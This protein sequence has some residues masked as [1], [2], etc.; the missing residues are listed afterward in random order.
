MIIRSLSL[1]NFGCLADREIEFRP[2][3]NVIRGPNEAGKST[4]QSALL[5]VLFEKVTSQAQ[6]RVL[7]WQRWGMGE[8]YRLALHFSVGDEEWEL[9]KD[10]GAPRTTLLN[11]S[12]GDQWSNPDQVQAKLTELLGTGSRG[13]Y[14]STAAIRQQQIVALETG[15]QIGE[16]LQESISGSGVNVS[17]P[18]VLNKLDKALVALQRGW[19]RPA[20]KNPGPMIIAKNQ[21][22]QLESQLSELQREGGTIQQARVRLE[23]CNN[24]IEQLEPDIKQR[25]QFLGKVEQRRELETELGRLSREW[26]ELNERVEQAE[27]LQEEINQLTS[28]SD[29]SPTVSQALAELNTAQQQLQDINQLLRTTRDASNRRVGMI[30]SG[31]LVAIA[32][33]IG[34][35][36]GSPWWWLLCGAGVVLTAV[37][38]LM[39]PGESPEHLLSQRQQAENNLI[40][41]ERR[42]ALAGKIAQKQEGLRQVLRSDEPED[43][44]EQRD[45]LAMERATS[46]TRLESPDLAHIGLDSLEIDKLKNKLHQSEERLSQLQREHIEAQTTIKNSRYDGE[47]ELHTDEQL[48]EMRDRLA[49]LQ[50]RREVYELTREALEAAYQQTLQGITEPLEQQMAQMLKVLTQGR[51]EQIRVDNEDFQPVVFSPQKGG[52]AEEG[53]LSCATTEQLYL[54][55]RLAL[56]ELLW[57]AQ[58]PPLLLDDPLVNFDDQ[59]RHAAAQ[60]LQDVAQRR[61]ILLFTC[62]DEYDAYVD[63]VIEL[64]GPDILSTSNARYQL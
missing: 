18:E 13:V 9:V 11:L 53:D 7:R 29:A 47:E 19:D 34:A 52:E 8:M 55:A 59:R 36:V 49:R 61:Q 58:G 5:T 2:T 45:N 51:Y 62:S 46:Q 1:R 35:I 10:F 32:G 38:A 16:M 25:Q 3:L 6:D 12:T 43:L 37:G 28:E 42:V 48:H 44:R 50:R 22:D 24:R 4:L 39:R 64:P 14:E 30:V 57:P 27:K 15:D 54:A 56:T 20:P 26:K 23:E 60:L 21:I 41:A 63:H 33:G 17:V 40:G 31:L